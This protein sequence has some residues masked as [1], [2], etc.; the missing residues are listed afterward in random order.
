[1]AT[2]RSPSSLAM[3]LNEHFEAMA[4][5]FVDSAYVEAGDE[6]TTNPLPPIP[7]LDDIVFQ[8]GWTRYTQNK[9][10]SFKVQGVAAPSEKA[11]VFD[12]ETFVTAGAFPVIG[13]AL[14]SEAAY[15]WLCQPKC[16]TQQ[17]Q[18]QSGLQQD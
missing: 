8:P 5:E 13:S 10:G 14:S 4:G 12:T 3:T 17:S 2:F 1:M 6:F 7:G 15:V 16:A 11:Y 18:N 9:D